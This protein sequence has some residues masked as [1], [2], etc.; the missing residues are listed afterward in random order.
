MPKTV[1]K[2]KAAEKAQNQVVDGAHM[3]ESTDELHSHHAKHM[4]P[5]PRRWLR[6]IVA[7]GFAMAAILVSQR[8]S[9]SPLIPDLL[10]PAERLLTE[11]QAWGNF[12][13]TGSIR[14]AVRDVFTTS[15]M[16]TESPVLFYDD[17]IQ[18]A[19]QTGVRRPV[20]FLPGFV[21][22]GLEL[23]KS[24]PCAKAKFRERIWGTASMVK[25]FLTNPKCWIEHMRLIP[26]YSNET[27]TG[28]TV[29]F[30]E[31]EG[32]KI[33]AT[34]G[35]ASADFVIGD[36]CVWNPIIEA[37]GSAGYDE[38][39]MWMMSYDWRL[40]L[41]DFEHKNQYFS[42]MTLEIEKLV[43]LNKERV[44][45]VAHSFG[46]KVWF[47]FLQW[48][49]EHLSAGWIE[50]NLFG[51]FHIGPV[52]LGVPKAIA[53]TLSGDTRDT[54]QLG[55]LSTLVDTVLPPA[56]RSILFSGWGSAVDMLPMGGS[57][58]WKSPV[59]V[60]NG[61]AMTI[62][63]ALDFLFK[64]SAMA[65]HAY[66]RTGDNT[67]LRCPPNKRDKR[68]CYRDDWTDP[69]LAPLPPV[70]KMKIWCT[71]GVGIP[72]E[73][74]YHYT[75]LTPNLTDNNGMKLEKELHV[76]NGQVVNG[77]ML[78]DGDG[79]VP[80]ES[81]GTTC[82]HAWR[83][84]SK[85]NPG[86]VDVSVRELVHGDSYSVLSRAGAAGGSSVDHV[87]IMGNGQ[88]IRDI[89]LV[90]LGLEAELDPPS[91]ELALHRLNISLPV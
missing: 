46:S 36:Y 31:P 91:P 82:V 8:P 29:H 28:R 75:S 87:D 44:L 77:V 48:A 50:R 58:V 9:R 18:K 22:S 33:Q 43:E 39:S 21:T 14:D 30:S 78:D 38:G 73:T 64:T 19:N 52:F 79:T 11:L 10:S 13:M 90:A 15:L 53:A 5:R 59:L 66:H 26:T 17:V 62:E 83:K 76:E 80:L 4:H 57:S 68:S 3:P 67:A 20:L 88:V 40:P 74:G 56:D 51:T 70:P 72:T 81:L 55:A 49:H 45:I 86:N 69:S 54:A 89:L 35:L 61:E 23:W 25:L 42:R 41:R 27:A 63:P 60:L 34:S 65:H 24:R 1:R 37:L 12:T 85:L 32:I 47:F 7:V 6:I 16:D 84:D 71:Y 2:S